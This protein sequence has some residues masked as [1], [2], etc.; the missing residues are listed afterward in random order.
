MTEFNRITPNKK[1]NNVG[2][3]VIL[4]ELSYR[5][6]GILF[7]IHR[8]LGPVHKEKNYQDAIEVALKKEEVHF[9][10]EKELMLD[11]EGEELRGFFVDFI[12]EDKLILEIKA[13]RF[14]THEDKRQ[15]LRYLKASNLPLAIIVNFKRSKL[16]YLRLINPLVADDY[17]EERYSGDNSVAF[18]T[19]RKK[20]GQESGKILG[21]DYGRKHIGLAVTDDS[22]S[23]AF[24]YKTL[25]VTSRKTLFQ[26]LEK[27]VEFEGI[28]RVV[29]GLPLTLKGVQGA[30]SAE[31]QKFV[32][33]VEE[34]LN[35]PVETVDERFTTAEAKKKNQGKSADEHALAAQLCLEVYLQNEHNNID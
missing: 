18:G 3:H 6:M 30:A 34:F 2:E 14:I 31:V 17:Q 23:M 4:P 33:D 25:E 15:T 13:K 27:I 10:R 32:C 5:L 20:F 35:V 19:I 24:P 12:I 26:Y 28:R 16:E 22:G 9:T 8:E 1:P 29:V 21:I 11:Y 7:K